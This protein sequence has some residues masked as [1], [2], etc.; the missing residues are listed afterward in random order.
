MIVSW[1]WSMVIYVLKLN[2]IFLE[3]SALIKDKVY[4]N[5]TGQMPK[6]I[7]ISMQRKNH[8]KISPE[9]VNQFQRDVVKDHFGQ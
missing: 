7:A 2:L 1:P 8:L 5:D 9:L 6:I 4:I 3:T